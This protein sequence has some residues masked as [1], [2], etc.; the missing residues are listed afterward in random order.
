MLVFLLKKETFLLKPLQKHCRI[1]ATTNAKDDTSDKQQP[2]DNQSD[3]SNQQLTPPITPSNPTKTSSSSPSNDEVEQFSC[4][5]CKSEFN[6]QYELASHMTNVNCTPVLTTRCLLCDIEV[7][8]LIL[9][10]SHLVA[11]Y[12]NPLEN[13][14]LSMFKNDEGCCKQCHPGKPME[15]QDFIKH[16]A[17]DHDNLLKVISSEVKT[18]LNLVFP[19]NVST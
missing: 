8:S 5:K 2:N 3:S 14:V 1:E 19:E 6:S 18:H 10:K 13:E 12:Y 4:P 15:L 16:W 7:G 9:Y 11:H 17:V